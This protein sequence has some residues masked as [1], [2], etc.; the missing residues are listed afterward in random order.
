MLQH[1]KDSDLAQ[2][3]RICSAKNDEDVELVEMNEIQ[4]FTQV[5]EMLLKPQ[6]AKLLSQMTD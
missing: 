3:R 4:A 5:R 6:A 2:A 1:Y